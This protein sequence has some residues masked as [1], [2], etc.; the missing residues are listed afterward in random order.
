MALSWNEI[1]HRAMDFSRE[2][3]GESREHAE[4]KS[5]WDAFFHVFGINR[6]RIAAFEE[7]VKKLDSNYGF[8]DLFWK[9]TLLVEHKSRGKNLDKAYSQALDYFAG[10]KDHELPKYVLVSDFE[11]FRLY[12]L[13]ED[14]LH[15]FHL[16]QLH[17]NVNLFGFIAGY[18]Q[19][20]YKDEEPVNIAAAEKMGKLH[21][22]LLENG[23]RGHQLEVLLMRLLFCMFA[24]DTGIFEKNIF[25]DYIRQR[26]SED[27]SDL[28][29]HLSSIFQTLNT[30][31]AE[32]QRHM[33]EMLSAFPYVN[34]GLF[35]EILPAVYFD[36]SLRESL[37]ECCDFN[38]G[39][40][41]PAIFG[42]MFQSVMDPEKRR[43]IGAHYT[44]EK[45]ILK[46]IGPLF[47][48]ELRAEFEHLRGLKREK[49][50]RLM[51]FQRKISELGFFDPA[52]GCG[53]F[54]VITYRELRR[55]EIEI[56]TEIHA[57]QMQMGEWVS[58]VNVENFYGIEIEEFPARIAET[59]MWLMN[60]QMN[61]ELSIA[62]NVQRA[63]LPLI[64]SAHILNE[65]A[66]QTDWTE[67]APKEKIDYILGNPPFIGKHLQNKTQNED[68]ALIFEGVKNF[69]SLDY[70][71]AWY[72]K[73]AEYI[74][75]TR[76]KVAFVSTNS[77][78]MGEQVG[79]LW[80]ELFNNYNIK[81][82]F[83]HRTFCWTSEARG[84][85]AVHVVI[86]GFGAFDTENKRLFEYENIKGEPHEI[87][88]RNIN[89]LLIDGDDIIIMRRA[90]PLSDVPKMVYGNKPVDGGNLI[91][92]DGEK[93]EFLEKQPE[94][95]K[96]IK[97]LL[98]GGNY[99]KDIP[100]WC[101][102]LVDAD[103]KEIRSMPH[104][105]ERIEKV[106]IMRLNSVDSG[107]RKL[108]E[109]PTQFRDTKNPESFILVPRVSSERRKY[110]PIGFFGKDTIVSDTCQSIPD[111]TLYHFGVLT[112][113]MHMA[114]VKYT[115]GRLESRFR[116]S[117]DIVYNNYPWPKD[118]S[119]EQAA[120]V[121]AAAQGV[122][123][124]RG[125]FP[126]SSLADLYDP[127]TMPPVLVKAHQRL[128]RAVDKC[129]RSKPFAGETERL[130]FLFA[131]YS[132]YVEP[133]VN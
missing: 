70:V 91:L 64:Q 39:V 16:S 81:I 121:E 101:L 94:A 88:A 47:L 96:F 69:K 6:R 97:P 132:E 115:C 68:M 72:I 85:A 35:E 34:G 126:D 80:N 131:L 2:W 41:S 93:Q 15:E 89:P 61:L 40:I 38:W 33:D 55:L 122:L 7:P 67:F 8:I 31:T 133:L 110:I 19:K 20:K 27:G 1:K 130:E 14:S 18:T 102:W 30:V 125:Q 46:L 127:L 113:E 4:A 111:A 50:K 11:R 116:Y 21:D 103:P 95:A 48:D 42:S 43:N 114:W 29:G 24:D 75:G 25:T 71:S 105:M 119:A 84:K 123:D 10:L 86:I 117:K 59:A 107:A 52:C 82:H 92:S 63:S 13:D 5:F 98:S 74:Q 45:N 17:S 53:N 54:L 78:T 76:K 22:G 99:L 49:E 44:S 128:D 58:M 120:A 28:G 3:Q 56:L 129:Y 73:A 124:A 57:G 108:A 60:H 104:L 37:L 100:R 12:D 36:S 112:S 79:I 90:K 23:Y 65:N 32:R 62:V 51:E 87:E 106:K 109:R 77:I 26:T 66:L 118:V 83:A 9:G